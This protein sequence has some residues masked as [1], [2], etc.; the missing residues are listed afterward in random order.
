MS[1]LVVG[2]SHRSAPVDLLERVSLSADAAAKL[3]DD[4]VSGEHA[5]EAMVLSTCNRVEVYVDV[6]KFHG[7]LAETSELLARQAGASL[8]ELTPHLYVHYEDRAVA[9][10]F[11]VACGLDSMVVGESQ[12]LGQVRAALRTAQDAGSAGRTLGALAQQALRVGKRARTETGID[13]AGRS[14]VSA[15]LAEAEQVL[16]SLAGRSVVVVGAGAMSSLAATVAHQVGAASVVVANR[17]LPHAQRVAA[18]VGGRAVALPELAGALASADLVVSCTGAVG[19]VVTTPTVAAAQRAR[20]DRPLVLLDLALPR[21]VEPGA[22]DLAGVTVIDLESLAGVLERTE[23]AAD[24]EATRLIVAEEVTAF[25]GWQ[26]AAS[27]APTVVALRGMADAVV[28]A[29]LARLTARLPGLDDRSRAEV[30]TTLQRVVEKVLH[31]PT[32]RVKQLAGEPGG[33]AYADA[34]SKLFG[35][36][37]AAV[38][39]VTRADVA[40]A[41]AEPTDG[42]ARN[43]GGG[44]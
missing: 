15:G 31:A 4:I 37:P 17:T 26:R 23:H 27:V 16:G 30:E 5:G 9:H 33:H 18:G 24:V 13:R 41:D 43:A 28:R 7:G 44:R 38:E 40:L 42:E 1:I 32:V 12:I 22:E 10:L 2:L 36:D 19:H 29:E 11:A 25:L 35:L 14:L 20:G 3:I 8:D 21:D 39:A 6:D 34:L